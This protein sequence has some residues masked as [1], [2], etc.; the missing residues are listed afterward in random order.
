MLA[1]LVNVKNWLI[2]NGKVVSLI[3]TMLVGIAIPQ[4]HVLTFL[5]QYLLMVMLFFAFLDIEISKVKIDLRVI[6]VLAANLATGFG[7]YLLFKQIN[8]E[9]AMTA[10]ITAMAPT[11][12]SSTVIVS[13]IR[14]KVDF[15]VSSVL[16]TNTTVALVIPLSIPFVVGTDAIISTWD[17]LL[18]VLITMF[19][20]LILSRFIRFLPKEVKT[21]LTIG[22]RF[23][24]PIWLF[25]LFII[26]AKASD[27][28][29]Q[30][31]SGAIIDLIEIAAMALLICIVNFAL[32]ALLGG[33]QYWREA[34]QALGQKNNS[35]A[36]WIALTFINPLAAMGPT[37]YI[38]FHNLY[39]TWQIYQ[40]EKR[41]KTE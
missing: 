39:N 7:W 13:F 17:V 12:I 28:I 40:Y 29:R 20:P 36:I 11:A 15:M 26:S 37:I 24:F 14:G 3:V 23:T 6:L 33:R 2:T 31:N 27:F 18:P 30:E 10:F 9:L 41:L 32:G 1:D 34:S 38:L 21:G 4:A 8:H 35:F 16:L 5:V 25:N 22:K 19:L